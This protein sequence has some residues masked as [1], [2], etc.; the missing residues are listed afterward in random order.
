MELKSNAENQARYRK[1]EKLKRKA[2]QLLRKLQSEP[3][4]HHQKN[5]Q[6]AH[7][8][9]DAAIKLPSN[10]TEKDYINA[11]NKLKHVFVE[12]NW[13]TNQIYTDILESRKITHTEI[14][15]HDLP[16]INSELMHAEG[17]VNALA[18]HIISAL[19]L[20]N[21]N[22]SDQAAALMEAMRFVGRSLVNNSEIPCSAATA[23]CLS[24][25]NPIYPR[26]EWY[27]KKLADTLSSQ[28][29]P[30]LIKLIVNNLT[31]PI[32]RPK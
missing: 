20:S 18:S 8:L 19:K 2:E 32:S 28:T 16:K 3:Y 24:T 30:D 17:R 1:K 22:E 23:L 10:W 12:L 27:S 6:E 13:P 15:P 25:I 21:C 29:H 26:P 4:K 31:S 7:Q 11:E 9:I 14:K 5:I